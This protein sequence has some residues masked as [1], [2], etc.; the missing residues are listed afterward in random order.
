[1]AWK[2][3]S[4]APAINI[5]GEAAVVAI[6]EAGCKLELAPPTGPFPKEQLLAYIDGADAVIAGVDRFD[7]SILTSLQARNLK[8]ISRWGV[9]YDAIDLA[10]ASKLGVMVTNTPGGLDEAVANYTFAL[11]L[12]VA[13]GLGEGH[14]TMRQGQWLPAWG[15]DVH[16]KTLG[17]IGY[18]R[19]GR[20][21]AKRALGFNMKIVAYDP[22]PPKKPV[23]PDAEF[24]SLDTLLARS[25]YIC[26]HAVLTGENHGMIGIEELKRMKPTAYLI[27]TARGALV[28]ETALVKAL[29]EGMIGGAALDA[30][31]VE[32]LPAEHP[33]RKAPRLLMTPHQASFG[34]DTGRVVSMTAAGAVIDALAGRTPQHV[35]NKEVLYSTALRVKLG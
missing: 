25:D 5:V 20:A 13:R 21:V 7:E 2:V 1:M 3:I 26:L 28:D 14:H 16:G 34:R 23:S 27:N 12:G 22:Y 35:V 10:V 32:P 29:Q 33:L 15:E 31:S 30:F 9:G 6:R 8:I 18:G 11:L 17:I 24:V 19:I 4:T